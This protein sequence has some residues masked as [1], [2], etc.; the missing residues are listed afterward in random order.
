MRPALAQGML[1]NSKLARAYGGF[2]PIARLPASAAQAARVM[3]AAGMAMSLF[4]VFCYSIVA[5]REKRRKKKRQRE[6]QRRKAST[7]RLRENAANL[8][9]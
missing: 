5:Q 3:S 4:G 1:T 7:A 8:L 2:A 9:V 6:E